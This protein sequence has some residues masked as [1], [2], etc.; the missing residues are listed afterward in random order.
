MPPNVNEDDI[1]STAGQT[2]SVECMFQ[3]ADN[4]ITPPTVQWLNSA[5]SV[6]S[7]N[8]T[9]SFSTLRTSHGGEYTCNVTINIP[10]L[11][12]L[13]TDDG[14]IRLIVESK[15]LDYLLCVL[16]LHY[17]HLHISPNTVP[18]PSVIIEEVSMP[19]NG[20]EYILSCIVTVDDSVNTDI[21]ISSQWLDNGGRDPA[22]KSNVHNNTKPVGNLEQQ[23]NLTFSPLGSQ[24]GGIYTCTTTISP[25]EKDE[26]IDQT[27][28]N[29]VT[30]I[31]VKS[32]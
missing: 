6:E 16:I 18:A 10:Q 29:N 5:G 13:L 23:H 2:F 14:T 26:F 20:S 28:A 22:A 31:H 25:E 32:K 3:M 19:F 9:L 17:D 4:L 27:T 1:S 21:T 7:D 24:D 11:N 12:I 15:M 30:D 8:S